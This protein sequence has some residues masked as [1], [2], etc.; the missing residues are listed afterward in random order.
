MQHMAL[1]KLAGLRKRVPPQPG[2]P[3]LASQLPW[4]LSDPYHT[5]T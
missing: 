3:G 4:F 2:T 5:E 1:A